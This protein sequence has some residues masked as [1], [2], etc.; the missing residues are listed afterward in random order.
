M[1]FLFQLMVKKICQE[2]VIKSIKEFD[3]IN[4]I[5]MYNEIDCKMLYN[6]IF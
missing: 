2:G 6:L 1:L 5:V 3:Y 4:D